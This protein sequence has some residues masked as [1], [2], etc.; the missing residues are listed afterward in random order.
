M[1]LLALGPW[2]IVL[3]RAEAHTSHPGP[4]T[5][6]QYPV[7]GEGDEVWLWGRKGRGKLALPAHSMQLNAVLPQ[8]VFPELQLPR[9]EIN[10]LRGAGDANPG[11]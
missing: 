8:H 9:S 11:T 7:A 4:A 3:W 6:N 5:G 2:D 10:A 1:P